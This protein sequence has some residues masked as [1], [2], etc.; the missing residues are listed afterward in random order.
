M[1]GTGPHGLTG[2]Q[3]RGSSA[4]PQQPFAA[5]GT[6]AQPGGL[7]AR[8]VQSTLLDPNGMPGV[9]DALQDMSDRRSLL[10]RSSVVCC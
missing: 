9:L 1:V 3:S 6:A 4:L 5:G 8:E 2:D 10:P 7:R